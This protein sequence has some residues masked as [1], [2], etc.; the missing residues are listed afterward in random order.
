MRLLHL[1]VVSRQTRWTPEQLA[2]A[3]S[4]SRSYRQLLQ[5]IGLRPCGG[6]YTTIHAYITRYRID[7]S[8][9]LGQGWNLGR[10]FE[11]RPTM[12]LDQILV[13][14]SSYPTSKV[15]ARL[16][17]AGLKQPRCEVCG[18]SRQSP[19]GRVPVELHHR[20][21]NNRDH[22]LENL[23]ILCPNCH[24]LDPHYRGCNI[25]RGQVVERQTR[26]S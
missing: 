12:P 19:D 6:N 4:H 9:F 17:R 14:D 25:G 16:F 23:Q 7:V 11:P 1:F 24:S 22:R 5:R 3:A 20:N 26:S 10:K 2:A 21:G 18:W 15:K 13:R 8:H